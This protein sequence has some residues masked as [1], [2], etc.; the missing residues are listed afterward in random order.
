MNFGALSILSKAE[1]LNVKSF[2]TC[3]FRWARDV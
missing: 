1:F 3:N 2:V